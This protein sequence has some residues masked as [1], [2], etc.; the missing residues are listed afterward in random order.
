ME[1]YPQQAFVDVSDG[2]TGLQLCNRGLP[3]FEAVHTP[4]GARLYLTLLRSVGR[5]GAPA[6]ADHPAPG[7]YCLGSQT[8][9]YALRSHTGDVYSGECTAAAHHYA[10]PLWCA[11]GLHH[12][13]SLPSRGALA[14]PGAG[15]ALTAL[16][17]AEAGTDLVMRLWN[18]TPEDKTITL[19]G[20]LPIQNGWT[21][22]MKEE[23]RAACA[24]HNGSLTCAA[25]HDGVVTLVME[26]GDDLIKDRR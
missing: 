12:P 26:I 1:G 8:A 4:H 5:L 9:E 18:T 22:D 15:I 19:T 6:G 24:L 14:Q 16:K 3:E 7:A 17:K 25:K 20:L 10:A 11:G 13:G 23:N 2:K 21:T